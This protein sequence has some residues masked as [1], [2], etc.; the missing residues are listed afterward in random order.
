ML[1]H[2]RTLLFST[3]VLGAGLVPVHSLSLS[4]SCSASLQSLVQSEAA[5]C[6]NG[7][8]LVTAILGS[9]GNNAV[10]VPAIVDSW[11]SKLCSSGSCT[12]EN[13]G[14]AAINLTS[15]CSQ[16]LAA[17]GLNIL[18]VQEQIVDIA[19]KA[20]PTVRQIACLKD[21]NTGQRCAVETLSNVDNAIG[22]LNLDGLSYLNL[23]LDALKLVSTGAK[24][25][26]CTDCM[27]ASF[28]L[29]RN[30][31]PSIVDQGDQTLKEV[32]GASFVDGNTPDGISQTATSGVFVAQAT[33]NA[34][35][36][37][38]PVKPLGNAGMVLAVVISAFVFMA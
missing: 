35:L 14:A 5:A 8:A 16:D 9:Q 34:A 29:A 13:I 20:Y 15:G 12:D 33:K 4:S 31:F 2:T 17:L 28:N 30:D 26:A 27:K 19:K 6:L 32:C 25:L 18:G 3:I 1:G 23:S 10:S 7:P 36:G 11:L 22:G 21:D 37:L 24:D 38:H